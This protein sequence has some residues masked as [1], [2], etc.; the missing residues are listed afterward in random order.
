M[1]PHHPNWAGLSFVFSL[2]N[3]NR[4]ML[5]S[6]SATWVACLCETSPLPF[7]SCLSSSLREGREGGNSCG[8]A[9]WAAGW[10]SGG[11]LSG[12]LFRC[13]EQCCRCL[14]SDVES[15]CSQVP[16]SSVWE[17][18]VLAPLEMNGGPVDGARPWGTVVS[19]SLHTEVGGCTFGTRPLPAAQRGWGHVMASKVP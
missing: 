3:K 13:G 4:C 2:S 7:L 5:A 18:S 15:I 10:G 8:Q 11:S 16:G 17:T 6:A 1:F 19:P 9:E 14:A 12:G